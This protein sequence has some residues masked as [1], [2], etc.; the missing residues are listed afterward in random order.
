[1]VSPTLSKIGLI[2]GQKPPQEKSDQKDSDSE[3]KITEIEKQGETNGKDK[4]RNTENT[5]SS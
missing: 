1:M 5:G 4:D 2:P 3:D